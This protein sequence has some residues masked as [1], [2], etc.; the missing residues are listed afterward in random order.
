MLIEIFMHNV[1]DAIICA[2][3]LSHLMY[4]DSITFGSECCY[5]IGL[6]I[7]FVDLQNV[8]GLLISQCYMPNRSSDRIIKIDVMLTVI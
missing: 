4:H 1:A 6:F 2:N 8:C 5:L 3:G 7:C